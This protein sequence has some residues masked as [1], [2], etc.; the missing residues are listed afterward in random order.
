MIGPVHSYGLEIIDNNENLELADAWKIFLKA[1]ATNDMGIIMRLSVG[2]IRC[3]ACLDNTEEEDKEMTNYRMTEPDWYEKLYKEIIFIP[4]DRFCR[5]DYPIIFT[6]ELIEKIQ[7]S[8]PA[9]AVEDF[10]DEKI[11]EVIIETTKP[12]ELSPG[13]EGGQH[14]FQFIKT[15][16]GYRFWGIDT[17]P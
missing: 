5:Q 6:K 3:L 11:Y 12:G 1:V 10:D 13:H 14:L 2:K 8:N 7:N 4:V 15:K 16:N 17:I 9:Y